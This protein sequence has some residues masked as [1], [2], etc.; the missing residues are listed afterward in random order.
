ML[1][2]ISSNGTGSST[3]YNSATNTF[4]QDRTPYYAT[5]TPIALTV[6]AATF[7]T[8]N[9]SGFVHDA[10]GATNRVYVQQGG[11]TQVLDGTTY[12][13]LSTIGF[14]GVVEEDTS[15]NRIYI[16]SGSV[17]NVY[18]GITNALIDAIN[19]PG[20]QFFQSMDMEDGS[21]RLYVI[22]SGGGSHLLVYDTTVQPSGVPEPAPLALMLVG[23]FAAGFA[24]TRRR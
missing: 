18:D 22:T 1:A 9:V 15:L 7:A 2:N 4:F 6:N 24:R 14:G 8:G 23:L 19:L 16:G 17:I 11:S 3:A 13:V 5:F 20:G 21:N 12:A 10:N